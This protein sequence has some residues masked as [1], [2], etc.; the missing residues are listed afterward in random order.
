M[1][2]IT[3]VPAHGNMTG[4]FFPFPV[5]IGKRRQFT[6]DFLPENLLDEFRSFRH[7]LPLKPEVS[8][9]TSP[10]ASMEMVMVFMLFSYTAVR[11]IFRVLLTFFS[12]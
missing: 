12:E 2:G 11:V 10:V 3:A 9:V 7:D 4:H 8:K 5:D 6:G 1:D